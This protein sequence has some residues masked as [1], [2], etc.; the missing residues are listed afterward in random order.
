MLVI[1]AWESLLSLAYNIMNSDNFAAEFLPVHDPFDD[2]NTPDI[3]WTADIKELAH[4]NIYKPCESKVLSIFEVF[5]SLS[6]SDVEVDQLAVVFE[7]FEDAGEEKLT[8]R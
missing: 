1:L 5:L 8:G 6:L 2:S 3:L 4:F 7:V